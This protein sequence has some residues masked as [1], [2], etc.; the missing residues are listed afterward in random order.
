MLRRV[1]AALA[2][3]PTAGWALR[4]GQQVHGAAGPEAYLLA[5]R[6][7]TLKGRAGDITCP[8]FAGNAEGDD[9]SRSAPR[10]AEALTCPNEFVTFTAA[11]GAGDHCEAGART[12]YHARSFGWLDQILKGR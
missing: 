1:L 3:K 10:L 6:E 2:R 7:Y 12:P 8:V 5:L 11:E 9:I 4:R